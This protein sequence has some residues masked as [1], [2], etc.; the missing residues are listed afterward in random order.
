MR[1]IFGIELSAAEA[2][3]QKRKGAQPRGYAAP[4][5]TGPKGETCGSCE[6]LVRRSMGKTYLKCWKALEKWT[7]GRGSDVLARAPSCRLWQA[8]T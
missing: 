1:D 6:H 5:G 2:H 4:P 8:K 7:S 3:A